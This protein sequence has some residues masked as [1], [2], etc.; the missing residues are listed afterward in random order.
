MDVVQSPLLSKVGFG[1]KLRT[2]CLKLK[3]LVSTGCLRHGRIAP[4]EKVSQSKML[5]RGIK[6]I[7]STRDAARDLN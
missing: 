5:M 3:W 7:Y 1:Q 4:A 2:K 6:R